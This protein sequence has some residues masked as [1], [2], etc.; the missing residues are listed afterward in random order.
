MN[1]YYMYQELRW[2]NQGHLLS[3]LI[4]WGLY[5]IRGMN[6]L[7]SIHILI[8]LLTIFRA[9]LSMSVTS[10]WGFQ[11]TEILCNFVY[12][13]WFNYFYME[14]FVFVGQQGNSLTVSQIVQ[15][16]CFS[17]F[18]GDLSKRYVKV[19]V[20]AISFWSRINWKQNVIL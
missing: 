6:C 16:P 12:C 10:K 15:F 9:N 4:H 20:V 7:D 5:L 17:S 19:H 1:L 2:L 14:G 3:A 13:R 18:W 8:I 11:I